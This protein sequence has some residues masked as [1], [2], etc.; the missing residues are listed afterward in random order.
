MQIIHL[1]CNITFD[2]FSRLISDQNL[3]TSI[4]DNPDYF[5]ARPIIVSNR[6]GKMIILAGNQRFHAGKLLKLETVPVYI[7]E[8]LTIEREREI[9]IRDNV[10]NG[11]WNF[12]LLANEWDYEELQE[13]GLELPVD[14][15]NIDDCSDCLTAF[16]TNKIEQMLKNIVKLTMLLKNVQKYI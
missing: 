16:N 14:F 9:I 2:H 4:A 11:E 13:W 5:N 3:V 1:Y 10:S 12:E 8:N 15:N 6:T 7:L